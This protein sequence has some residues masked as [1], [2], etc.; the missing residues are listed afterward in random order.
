[1]LLEKKFTCDITLILNVLHP[2]FIHIL[3][4]H[5][6]TK[7]FPTDGRLTFHFTIVAIFTF[8]C[9]IFVFNNN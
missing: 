9:Y 1:M 5:D 3:L 7:L 6:L 2:P 8:K 4:C